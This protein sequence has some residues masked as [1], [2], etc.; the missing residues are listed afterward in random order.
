MGSIF[1]KG[2]QAAPPLSPEVNKGITQEETALTNLV[3]QQTDQSQ[4]LFNLTEPGLNIAEN[5]YE[6][7]ASGD[8]GAI[9]RATAPMAQQTNQAATGAK[10]NIMANAPAGG[11]KNLALEEVDVNRGAQIAKTASGAVQSAPESL[12]K[13]AGQGI[14]ESQAGTSLALGGIGTGLSGY[15]SLGNM[16]FQQQ[17]LLAQE[18]GQ[19][20]GAASSAAGDVAM[21]LMFA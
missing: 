8:P 13:L 2:N 12:G 9:M 15:T 17:Q 18:K 1:G 11:E 16:Q 14:G 20:M 5:W 7:L 21:A 3:K 19:T 6:T 4:T 10:A